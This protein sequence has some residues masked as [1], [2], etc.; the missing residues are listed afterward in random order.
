MLS[1]GEKEF[2]L[3]I[4][5]RSIEAAVTK[6][7][8]AM[9]ENI[10]ITLTENCGAFVTL[11]KGSE[12]RGCIGYIEGMKPLYETISDAAQKAALEDYRFM[13]VTPDELAYIKIEIS[14]LSPLK[15][16]NNM[17][18]IEVGKHGLIIEYQY[19]RGLLLP[20][21]ATEYGWNRQTFLNQTAHKAGLPSDIWKNP[22]AKIFIFTAEIFHED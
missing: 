6:K 2:L 22:Q 13:P 18:E 9:P 17:D 5:R 14:V 7:G 16:I 20:Q 8:T 3:F 12:L 21:V 11:H 19:N 10:P 15:L 4:A 1:E